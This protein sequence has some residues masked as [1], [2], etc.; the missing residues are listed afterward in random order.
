MTFNWL[1]GVFTAIFILFLLFVVITYGSLFT[2]LKETDLVSIFKSSTFLRPLFF[3]LL[4]SVSAAALAGLVAIP[5]AYVLTRYSF[6]GKELAEGFLYLPVIVPPLV[7]GLALLVLFSSSGGQWLAAQGLRF[8]F[9]P[10][11]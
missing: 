5:S 4:S 10:A 9:S 2:L 3:S 7:S 6:P 8:V 11:G 1:K